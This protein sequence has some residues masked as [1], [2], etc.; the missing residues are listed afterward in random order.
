MLLVDRDA[1]TG[2]PEAILVP[3]MVLRTLTRLSATP[4][5][6]ATFHLPENTPACDDLT[7]NQGLTLALDRIQDPGNLGTILRTADWMGVRRIVASP[8]TVDCFNP[9]VIQASMGAVAKIAV[10][11]TPLEPWLR[12]MADNQPIYGTFLDGDNIYT[13]ALSASAVVVMGNEGSGISKPIEAL[14]NHRLFIPPG[15]PHASESLNVGAATAVVLSQ[16]NQRTYNG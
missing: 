1:D 13:S 10:R 11:Y 6:I 12:L 8:D 2:L 3:R 9:K 16:F 14:V 15:G 7:T 5:V 4:T